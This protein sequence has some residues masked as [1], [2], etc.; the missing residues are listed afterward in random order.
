M[1][2]SIRLLTISLLLLS[3]LFSSCELLNGLLGVDEGADP[4][5]VERPDTK[6]S[7]QSGNR[8]TIEFNNPLDLDWFFMFN[9]PDEGEFPE[10]ISV[11]DAAETPDPTYLKPDRDNSPEENENAFGTPVDR[12]DLT[13]MID[14]GEDFDFMYTFKSPANTTN[15]FGPFLS[16]RYS[17]DENSSHP[18][19]GV[20]SVIIRKRPYEVSNGEKL[21]EFFV[22]NYDPEHSGENEGFVGDYAQIDALESSTW[23]K[24][25]V[26]I[27]KGNTVTARLYKAQDTLMYTVTYPFFNGKKESFYNPSFFAYGNPELT[28]PFTNRYIIGKMEASIP[29]IP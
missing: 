28:D 14:L 9:Y 18:E 16:L 15:Y 21:Y 7:E 25:T 17:F 4:E 3:L 27:R 12:A 1:K 5:S 24:I 26:E 22:D 10:W 19:E 20:V 8:V 13:W 23:Y 2:V 6:L 11:T 29:A